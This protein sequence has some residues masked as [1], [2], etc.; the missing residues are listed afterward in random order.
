M[1]QS[2]GPG[3]VEPHGMQR[4]KCCRIKRG[5]LWDYKMEDEERNLK[6]N[7]KKTGETVMRKEEI[8]AS[9]NI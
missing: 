7:S 2:C 9:G 4:K 3:S 5:L 6:G 8:M 1:C